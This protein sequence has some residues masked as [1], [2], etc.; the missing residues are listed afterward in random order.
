MRN[1]RKYN[2]KLLDLLANLEHDQWTHWMAYFYKNDTSKNRDRWNKQMKTPYL[3]L[4]EK[5]RESGKDWANKV[6]MII[7]ANLDKL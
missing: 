1:L 6:L 7:Y 5:E 4:S 2:K 3:K